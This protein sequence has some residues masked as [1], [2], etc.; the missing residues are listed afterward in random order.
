MNFTLAAPCHFGLESVVKYELQKIGAEEINASDGKVT[1]TG[2]ERMIA[3]ANIRLAS[4]ERVRIVLA[5]SYA[6]SFPELIA[7]VDSIPWD[8]YIGRDDAFQ[9]KGSALDSKLSSVPKLQATVKK[10]AVNRLCE[11]YGMSFCAE[12]GPM[13]Q[14]EFVLRKNAVSVYLDTSGEGLHKR[15]YRRNSNVAPIKET[16]ASGIIDLARIRRQSRVMDP[17]CG[18]GTILIESVFKAADIAPGLN[19]RFAAEGWNGLPGAG[20]SINTNWKSMWDEERL[21]AKAEI[22]KDIEFSAEG[23]DYDPECVALTLDNAKKAG[24]RNRVGAKNRDFSDFK[25]EDGVIITN[26][27]YGERLLEIKE[28]EKLYR[29]MGE[30]FAA[31]RE[32]PA[33]IISPHEEFEKFFGK[34]AAKKRK[35]YNGMIKCF[36][37]M[38]Y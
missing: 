33:Y 26:P 18:S 24:V 35:L 23:F 14:I 32:H 7:A 36:L 5:E 16:L 8:E 11:T 28:A 4:A 6:D 37:Y 12:T 27:P 25:Q 13:H 15:G 2:D 10:S 19:R 21:A 1:F 20:D 3:R 34:K 38:Y 22:G 9:V 29:M 17:F 31:D 30:R